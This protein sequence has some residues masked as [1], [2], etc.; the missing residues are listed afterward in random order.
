M[1]IKKQIVILKKGTDNKPTKNKSFK[2]I[3]L[4]KKKNYRENNLYV[5][6]NIEEKKNF[7]NLLLIITIIKIKFVIFFL[8]NMK[9]IIL[10][11]L[12]II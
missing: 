12:N 9:K 6:D 5:L 4:M 8:K 2:V 7:I 3:I 11:I 10:L 1:K